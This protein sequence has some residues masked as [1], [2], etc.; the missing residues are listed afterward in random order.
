MNMENFITKDFYET[1]LLLSFN[2]PLVKIRRENGICFFIFSD[3]ARS[4]GLV[5]SYWRGEV[6]AELRNFTSCQKL[7][8]DLIHRKPEF[9]KMDMSLSEK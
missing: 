7:V 1:A 8:K 2:I 4:A 9:Q 5:E 6:K 3:A